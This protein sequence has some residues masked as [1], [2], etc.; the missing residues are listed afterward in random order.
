MGGVPAWLLQLVLPVGFGLI[1]YRYAL[2]CGR[3]LVR[4]VLGPTGGSAAA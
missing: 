2:F 4:L 3:D 1:C